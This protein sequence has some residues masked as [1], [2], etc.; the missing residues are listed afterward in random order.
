MEPLVLGK[1]YNFNPNRLFN[2][3]WKEIRSV[4]CN[5]LEP[6]ESCD[7]SAHV[8]ENATDSLAL[9]ECGKLVVDYLTMPDKL[10]EF[11]S[12]T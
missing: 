8:V 9:D 12:Q 4:C 1:D 3:Q 2:R 5:N 11:Y 7:F 10:F 6:I